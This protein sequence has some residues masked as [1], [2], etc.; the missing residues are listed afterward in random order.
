ML[1]KIPDLIAY[2]T[3][4]GQDLLLRARNFGW[5]FKTHVYNLA[6]SREDRTVFSGMVAEGDHV[7]KIYPFQF[8]QALGPLARDVHSSLIHYLDGSG[9]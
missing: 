2:P 1:N 7:V 8:I 6:F 9:I 4:G 3:K 5:V